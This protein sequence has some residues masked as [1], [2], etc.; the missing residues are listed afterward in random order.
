MLVCVIQGMLPVMLCHPLFLSVFLRDL[1]KTP[2]QT[3]CH[4]TC[5]SS[6]SAE[7]GCL[8]AMSVLPAGMRSSR[9]LALAAAR[10]HQTWRMSRNR[11]LSLNRLHHQLPDHTQTRSTPTHKPVSKALYVFYFYCVSSN[12]VCTSCVFKLNYLQ[13]PL[14]RW[15]IV[16][17]LINVSHPSFMRLI[18][19][20]FQPSSG[21][22]SSKFLVVS[23][24]LRCLASSKASLRY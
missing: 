23:W 1:R 5:M 16:S 11:H 10:Q 6:W 20:R 9:Q 21:S 12:H 15:C 4:V 19:F 2:F 24:D 7:V 13:C 22:A 17:I 14:C 8:R 18:L 3:S